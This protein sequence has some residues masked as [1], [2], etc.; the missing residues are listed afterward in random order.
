MTI[1]DFTDELPEEVSDGGRA[2]AEMEAEADRY[3]LF[4]R[5][6]KRQKECIELV[7]QGLKY[8][9]IAE[10]LGMKIGAVSNAIHEARKHLTK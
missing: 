8:H 2:V 10:K 9:E 7:E 4:K 5:L 1:Y 6:S 3:F